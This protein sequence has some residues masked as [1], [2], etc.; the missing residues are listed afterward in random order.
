MSAVTGF[1]PLMAMYDC[2]A[3]GQSAVLAGRQA[4]VREAAYRHFGDSAPSAVSARCGV[5]AGAHDLHHFA[6]SAAVAA[7]IGLHNLCVPLPNV[8]PFT[9]GATPVIGA[10]AAVPGLGRPVAENSSTECSSHACV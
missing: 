2:P 9:E 10:Q 6:G 7:P 3:N 1:C 8:R 4:G 5:R